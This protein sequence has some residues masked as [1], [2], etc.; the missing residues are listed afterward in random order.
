[1][2]TTFERQGVVECPWVASLPGPCDRKGSRS[3]MIL[4]LVICHSFS[5]GGHEKGGQIALPP[6]S[7]EG[8]QQIS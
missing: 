1:M 2:S 5:N 8:V 4:R 6:R 3:A 7:H